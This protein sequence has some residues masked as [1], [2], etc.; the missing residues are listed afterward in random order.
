MAG[1]LK[2]LAQQTLSGAAAQQFTSTQTIATSVLVTAESTNAGNLY[3]GDS[4]VAAT[5]GVLLAAGKSLRIAPI[6]NPGGSF[7][8]IDLS[9]LYAIGTASDKFRVSYT[10]PT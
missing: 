6:V 3:V 9:T 5:S 1:V 2:Q 7:E 4:G 10:K 8:K